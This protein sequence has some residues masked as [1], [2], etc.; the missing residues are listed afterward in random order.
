MIASLKR[1]YKTQDFEDELNREHVMNQMLLMRNQ[2]LV[3]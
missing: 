1:I 2:E 3:A